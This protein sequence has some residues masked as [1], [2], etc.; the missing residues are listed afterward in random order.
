VH[1]LASGLAGDPAALA[2]GGGDPAVEGGGELEG[3]GQ[4]LALL[5]R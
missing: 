3:D 2:G 5:F 1:R 4:S